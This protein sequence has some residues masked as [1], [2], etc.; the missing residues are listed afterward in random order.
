MLDKSV[1]SIQSSEIAN[2]VTNI[3]G[4]ESVRTVVQI[5]RLL[6]AQQVQWNGVLSGDVFRRPAASMSIV[7]NGF[8]EG[9]LK[10]TSRIYCYLCVS[11]IN[12][13]ELEVKSRATYTMERA[14]VSTILLGNGQ[15]SVAS[16][17]SE[18]T[19]S[20]TLSMSSSAEVIPICQ[21]EMTR[22]VLTLVCCCWLPS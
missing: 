20:F 2:V 18:S 21:S 13:V 12:K 4:F 16:I 6:M 10:C 1:S 11:E 14:P 5:V 9:T 22:F 19:E 15:A 17:V 7:L 3:M 8:S